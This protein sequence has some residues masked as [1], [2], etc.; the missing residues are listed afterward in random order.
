M[1]GYL[2]VGAEIELIQRYD[3]LNDHAVQKS[4]HKISASF[5]SLLLKA[6]RLARRIVSTEEF[7]TTRLFFNLL[8]LNEDC[9]YRGPS[10]H[11]VVLM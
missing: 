6:D 4:G 11:K 5:I 3:G 10:E 9:H 8:I 7:S 1:K 2:Q